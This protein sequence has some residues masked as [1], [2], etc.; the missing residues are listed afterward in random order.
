M[1]YYSIYDSDRGEN[2]ASELG[3]Q[4]AELVIKHQCHKS[5]REV[6]VRQSPLPQPPTLSALG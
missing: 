5:L 1:G 6:F 2:L 4:D 3:V